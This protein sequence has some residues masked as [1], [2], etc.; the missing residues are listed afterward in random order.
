[1]FGV[2]ICRGERRGRDEREDNSRRE[3]RRGEER[4]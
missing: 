3:E 1:M 2:V 4:D